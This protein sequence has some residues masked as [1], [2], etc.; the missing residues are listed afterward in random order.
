MTKKSYSKT[1]ED[2]VNFM[3]GTNRV[4]PFRGESYGN[5]VPIKVGVDIPKSEC[6][7]LF[8]LTCARPTLQSKRQ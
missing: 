5:P 4:E 1:L 2:Q 7:E 6:E 8:M 3:L